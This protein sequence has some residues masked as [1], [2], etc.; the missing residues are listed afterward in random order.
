[1]ADDESESEKKEKS[2]EPT[3]HKIE[4]TKKEGNVPFSKEVVNWFMV[5]ASSI[6]LLGAGPY[7]MK[8][9]LFKLRNL[10]EK[11]YQYSFEDGSVNALGN[12]VI[13]EVGV[14][15]AAL[16]I[17]FVIFALI[18][19]FIQTGMKI[20]KKALQPDLKKIS[21]I[22]GAKRLFSL[23]SVIELLKSLAKLV[24][25]GVILYVLILSKLDITQHLPQLPIAVGLTEGFWLIA[26][27]LLFVIIFQSLIA[28]ADYG[29]QRYDYM[30]NL[31]MSHKEIRDEMKDTD[32]NPE[33]KSKRRQMQRS[34]ASKRMLKKVPTATVVVTNPTHYAVALYYEINTEIPP[35]VVAK[36]VDSM[37][38]KI[39]ELALNNQ[40]PLIEN[41]PLARSLYKMVEIDK[42]IPKEHYQAVAEIIKY[43]LQRNTPRR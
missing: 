19:T 8:S 5:V 31:R 3:P 2:E 40:V 17:I 7:L 30:Q 10:T 35:V 14:D 37:A 23:K 38:Q 39:R 16:C 21:L 15:F 1:M 36:G 6:A 18:G 12:Q 22:G 20:K 29:Y 4:Q 26:K 9:I 13:L 28:G 43:V 24:I 32:G 34:M 42:S 41:P 27:I 11:A 25:I 33:I